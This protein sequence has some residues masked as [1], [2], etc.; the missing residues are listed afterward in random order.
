M[1]QSQAP[2]EIWRKS[3][4]KILKESHSDGF[5]MFICFSL[6]YFSWRKQHVKKN[7]KYKLV[8]LFEGIPRRSTN[9]YFSFKHLSI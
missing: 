9:L 4:M 5:P 6:V 3:K 8:F 1:F 7:E 2:S